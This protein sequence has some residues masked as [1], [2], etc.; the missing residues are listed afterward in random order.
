VDF[1]AQYWYLF[2][3]AIVSGGL[4]MWPSLGRGGGAS[5][6]TPPEAVQLMN[7]EKA[8]VVDVSEPAEF[9][10]GHVVGSRNIPLA[11]LEKTTDLPKN[12]ALPVVLVCATGTRASRAVATVKKLGYDKVHP[13]IGGISAWRDAGLPLE[14]SSS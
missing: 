13:M 1:V 4:L 7:R 14:K 11:G 3:A 12:K 5:R 9:A 8:V 6:V 2:L 10:A